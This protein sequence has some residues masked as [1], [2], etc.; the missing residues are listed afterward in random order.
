M[1]ILGYD[2]W[3]QEIVPAGFEIPFSHE[4]LAEHLNH[5]KTENRWCI[6]FICNTGIHWVLISFV[7]QE[8]KDPAMLY[9][10]STNAPLTPDY[11]GYNYITQL[12]NKHFAQFN[13]AHSDA[14]DANSS[15][16]KEEG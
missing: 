8:G 11:L 14:S 3:S 10:N 15:S 5:I 7:R 4:I 16:K 1:Y 2:N 12:Y 9:L 13:A 6:H